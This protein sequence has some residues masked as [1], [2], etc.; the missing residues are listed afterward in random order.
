MLEITNPYQ[1]ANYSYTSGSIKITGD[2][3]YLTSGM[4]KLNGSVSKDGTYIGTVNVNTVYTTEEPKQNVVISVPKENFR[5]V[6]N[7]TYGLIEEI[8]AQINAE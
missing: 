3:H 7:A 5:E 1:G 8:E 2:F 4:D 6:T